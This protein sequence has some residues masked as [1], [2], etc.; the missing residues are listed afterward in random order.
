MCD[1][2]EHLIRIAVI[3]QNAFCHFRIYSHAA[4]C[5]VAAVGRNAFSTNP[6]YPFSIQN[7]NASMLSNETDVSILRTDMIIE[8]GNLRC[9]YTSLLS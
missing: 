1:I 9:R 6:K 3:S 2:S 5:A 4:K 7:I 8:E